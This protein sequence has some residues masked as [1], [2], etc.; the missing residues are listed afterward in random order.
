MEPL[1]SIV[2]A[3]DWYSERGE[4]L[5]KLGF[6][7]PPPEDVPA[8]DTLDDGACSRSGMPLTPI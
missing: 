7:V 6:P 8:C 5:Q 2:A 3:F 1:T 4:Q